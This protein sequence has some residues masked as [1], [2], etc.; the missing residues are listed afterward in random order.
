[1]LRHERE[2]QSVLRRSALAIA[3]LVAVPLLAPPASAASLSADIVDFLYEPDPL[4]ADVGDSVTWTNRDAATHTVTCD[5]AFCAF[6]SPF[7]GRGATFTATLDHAGTYEY[8]CQLHPSMVGRIFVATGA[9][10]PDLAP[11]AGSIEAYRPPL[12]AGVPV[13]SPTT[14]V[15]AVEVANAGGAASDATSVAFYALGAD[16][17]LALVGEA[18]LASI[19]PGGVA[20]ASLAWDDAA[21]LGDATIEVVVDPGND[22]VE[23]SERNNGASGTVHVGMV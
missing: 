7:L 20:E 12:I 16:G 8:F 3:A 10:A 14:V 4:H 17:E 23:A 22:V 11:V 1:M 18:A 9:I 15:L 6:E 19:A 21:L 2:A 5:V 13:P